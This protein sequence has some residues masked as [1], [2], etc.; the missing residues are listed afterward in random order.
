MALRN[1]AH[2]LGMVMEECCNCGTPF[3]ITKE[4]HKIVRNSH[5]IFYCPKGHS[6]YYP[7]KS[8]EEKL[9]DE[10]SKLERQVEQK[11]KQREWA[12]QDA[13]N[14][15]NGE[16]AQKAAKTRLANKMAAGNC[17]CC[18]KHFKV[19]EKHMKNKHPDFESE[20]NPI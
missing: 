7:G 16:R 19:L 14:A 6:Q 8:E 5:E 18:K 9:R 12:E 17:P 15:R 11:Q 10:V 1:F 20:L 13:K 3:A 2:N 4:F